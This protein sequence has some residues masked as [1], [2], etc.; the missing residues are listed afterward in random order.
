VARTPMQA[1]DIGVFKIISEAGIAA[2]VRRIE[3]VAGRYAYRAFK[4]EEQ[5][6]MDIAQLLKASDLDVVPRVEKLVAQVKGLERSSTSSSISSSRP[7]W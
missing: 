6:I 7:G 1:A 5:N 4:R 3:A 2:G